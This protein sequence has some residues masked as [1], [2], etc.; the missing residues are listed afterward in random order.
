MPI[1]RSLP[2]VQELLC[3]QAMCF[4][5]YGDNLFSEVV[6]HCIYLNLQCISLMNK[7][8]LTVYK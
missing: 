2:D 3:G 5:G 8:G 4:L 6:A 7:Q 1:K